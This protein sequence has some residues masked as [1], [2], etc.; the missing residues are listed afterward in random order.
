MESGSQV[1]LTSTE[2]PTSALG[3]GWSGPSASAS[4]T[5][6]SAWRLVASSSTLLLPGAELPEAEEDGD[7][8]EDERQQVGPQSHRAEQGGE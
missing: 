5:G 7:R 1:P 3:N 4:G 2:R 8:H 6:S